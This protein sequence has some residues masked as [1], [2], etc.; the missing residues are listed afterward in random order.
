MKFHW[1]FVSCLTLLL[2]FGLTS[3]GSAQQ[4]PSSAPATVAPSTPS[5]PDAGIPTTQSPSLGTSA[6]QSPSIQQN[7]STD[8]QTGVT[9]AHRVAPWIFGAIALLV[10]IA[11][12]TAMRRRRAGTPRN[13]QEPY[14]QPRA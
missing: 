10:I 13:T 5:T 7:P 9:S 8:G 6:P 14:V 4:S 3:G 2:S 11:T 1:I 12:I